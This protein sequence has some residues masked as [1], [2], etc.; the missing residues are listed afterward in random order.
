M[1]LHIES[2]DRIEDVDGVPCR[3]WKGTTANGTPCIVLIHRI[4]VREDRDHEE[5]TRELRE[6]PEPAKYPRVWEE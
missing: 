1:Q 6:M 3:V 2:T 5:F 4:A